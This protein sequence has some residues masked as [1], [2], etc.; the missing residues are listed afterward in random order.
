MNNRLVDGRSSEISSHPVDVN[1]NKTVPGTRSEAW[2]PLCQYRSYE[3]LLIL[4]ISTRWGKWLG[5]RPGLTLP[6]VK[7]VLHPLDRKLGRHRTR[8]DGKGYT[9]VVQ[10]SFP[11]AM[12]GTLAIQSVL[13]HPTTELPW[14]LKMLT[15]HWVLKR[16][17]SPSVG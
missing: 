5:W 17:P 10:K 4:Y 13:C 6:P 7:E 12:D 1:N 16:S 2:R 9:G 15:E 3:L 14:V 8:L 11:P